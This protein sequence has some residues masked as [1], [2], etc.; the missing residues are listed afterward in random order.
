MRPNDPGVFKIKI[1]KTTKRTFY[2]VLPEYKGYAPEDFET[3]EE[4]IERANYRNSLR[5]A[6]DEKERIFKSDNCTIQKVEETI[7]EITF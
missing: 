7:I 6:K 2:R 5:I 3:L 4:A 1:M